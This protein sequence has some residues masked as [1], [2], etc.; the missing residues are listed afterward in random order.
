MKIK[1]FML[2]MM[3][4]AAFVACTNDVETVENGAFQ[5]GEKGY[6]SVNIFNSSSSRATGDFTEGLESE[7]AVSKAVFLFLDGEYKGCATPCTVT[8]F[9]WS[10][11]GVRDD[12]TTKA[13]T[14]VIDGIK[15][16]VPAYIVAVLNPTAEMNFSE[17]TSLDDLKGMVANYS[18]VSTNLVMSNAVYAAA[19]GKEVVAT[20]I[21]LENI[22]KTKQA[23]EDENYVPVT[24]QV[25]RV[26]AK[27]EVAK[28]DDAITKLNSEGLTDKIDDAEDMQLEFVLTGW[29]VLQNN[30]S[31]LIKNIDATNWT[32]KNWNALN[33]KRSYWA[34]DYTTKGRTSYE[35]EKLTGKDD[36]F[37]YVE[38]TV[39]QTATVQAALNSVSPYLLV[40]GK[41]VKAGTTEAVDLVEWRGQKYTK[42]GYLNLIAGMEKVSQYYTATTV[43]TSEGGVTKY[44]SFTADLLEL[45]DNADNDWGATAVLKDESTQFF[46]VT[47][48]ADGK[49]VDVATP[50]AIADVKAAIAEFKEVKFWN[51]GNTYYFVP[52][53]HQ[54]ATAATDETEA[55]NFYGVVRNH[56]YQMNIS[57]IKGYGTPVSNPNQAIEEPENPEEGDTYM[58]AEVVILDWRIVENNVELE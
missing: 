9:S 15:D 52:I 11:E 33:L 50:A 6:V 48:K 14:L 39:N 56:V 37:K 13:T 12:Q 32:I 34:N 18:S 17:S 55:T 53:K 22:A 4:S 16:E 8:N 5:A 51:G 42:E 38:E 26:V 19:N 58:Q 35:V 43:L 54:S 2:G 1:S 21:S 44:T 41:F 46:T 49:T 29:E 45:V 30:Q 28:L 25:E 7:S 10:T 36:E 40:S 24:I 47:F 31:R 23:L 27:V 20:P 57:K 3:A